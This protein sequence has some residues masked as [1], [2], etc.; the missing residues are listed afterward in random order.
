MN[1]L[2]NSFFRL[3][4]GIIILFFINGC[5]SYK[6]STLNHDPVYTV[7]YTL[8]VPAETKIDSITSLSDLRWK[9]RTDF[10]F[11]WDFAQY[12]M[13]QPYSWYWN[14]PRLDGIWRPYNRF[15][16]YFNSH[17]FWTDWAFHYPHNWGWFNWNTHYYYGWNR[18]YNPW[19]NWFDRPWN[20]PYNQN[21]WGSSR[22]NRNIAYINGRRGSIVTNYNNRTINDEIITRH[23]NPRRIINNNNVDRIVRDF[24]D[25]GLNVKIINNRNN[26]QINRSNPRIYLRPEG[27]SNGRGSWSG[28]NIPAKPVKPIITPPSQSRQIYRGSGSS[29]VQQSGTRSSSSGQRG[30]GTIRQRN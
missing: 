14:N 29:G 7:E 13:Q 22:G 17:W 15:D 24:K 6:L 5:A 9:L 12:A 26:D 25:R 18:P 20:Y 2:P 23:N 28:E 19:N 8:N 11:R 3:I 27:G 4:G 1:K 30:G 21:I 16:V 10:S